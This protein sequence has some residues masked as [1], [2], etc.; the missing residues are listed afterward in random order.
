MM[1]NGMTI[2]NAINLHCL[3][4]GRGFEVTNAVIDKTPG[5]GWTTTAF[6]EAENRLHLQKAVMILRMKKKFTEQ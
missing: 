6:D 1:T 5:K 4:T 2:E 3:P